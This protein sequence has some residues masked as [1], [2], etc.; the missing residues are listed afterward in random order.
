VLLLFRVRGPSDFWLGEWFFQ[1]R[2][3]GSAFEEPIAGPGRPGHEKGTTM[4]RRTFDALLSV[5]G[6]A[7]LTA[8]VGERV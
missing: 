3:V 1:Y 4:R 7:D 2:R 5:A 6:L 8:I